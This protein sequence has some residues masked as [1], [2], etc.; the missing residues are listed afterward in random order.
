MLAL[1][2]VSA[3]PAR[4]NIPANGLSL[5][6]C[7]SQQGG[8]A[9]I[10]KWSFTTKLVMCLRGTIIKAVA[11]PNNPAQGMLPAFS[12]FMVPLVAVMLIFA[13]MVFGIRIL[14]GEQDLKRRAIGFL[15]RIALV[16]FFAYNLGGFAHAMF[17]VMDDMLCL[18]S[19]P[20]PSGNIRSESIAMQGIW[21]GRANIEFMSDEIF[22]QC[23]PWLFIDNTIGRLFG[24]GETLLLSGG[25]LGIVGGSLFS[26]TIGMLIFLMGLMAF[27]DFLFLI[28]RLIFL[29]LTSVLVLAF[30]IIISPLIIPMALFYTRENYFT[31][32]LRIVIV[33]LLLPL[34]SFA[35]I[36]MFIGIYDI[37]L[38]RIFIIIGGLSSDGTPQFDAFWRMNQPKFSWLLP[39]DPNLAQ[40]FEK[41]IQSDVVGSPSV[42]TFTNPYARRALDAT[43]FIVAPGIDFGQAGVKI[44]QQLVLGFLSLW[45]FSSLMKSMLGLIPGVVQGIAKATINIGAPA[46]TI[47]SGMRRTITALG[48]AT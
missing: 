18:I 35:F 32:W 6:Q 29:Y 13:I 46:A 37:L 47:E 15:I 3:M 28:L 23:S 38:D 42:Q 20:I 4:A 19:Q 34:F 11:D 41:I 22:I 17:D 45:I 16:L 33:A 30:M 43:S 36:G 40:D 31:A 1:F 8:S 12:E 9:S 24:F 14:N 5:E 21:P 48:K 44:E 10:E 39:S 2:L 27:M 25:L 26:G 7:V